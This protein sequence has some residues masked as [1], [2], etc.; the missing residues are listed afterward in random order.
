MEF[1]T[2]SRAVFA[3]FVEGSHHR[4]QKSLSSNV[5]SAFLEQLCVCNG[6]KESKIGF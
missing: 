5:S 3:A 1:L 4:G 6:G 2:L